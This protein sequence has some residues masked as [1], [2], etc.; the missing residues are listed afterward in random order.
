[1]KMMKLALL[2]G[3]ALAVTAAGAQADDLDALKAEI[4]ALNARVAQLEAAP[5]V[6]AGYQLVT[7]T[8]GDRIVIPG[9]EETD[10]G[11]GKTATIIS[12][13]PTADAPASTSIEWSGYARAALVWRSEGADEH[14]PEE[15]DW[16]VLARGEIKVVGKTDTAVGEVGATVKIRGDFDGRGVAGDYMKEAWGW[17]AMTPELFLGGGYTGSLGNIGYGI[18]GSCNCYYTDNFIFLD[19]GDTTQMRLT[20]KSGPFSA[21]AAIEDG[22]VAGRFFPTGDSMGG[23]GEVKYSGDMISG[24]ISAIWLNR[25]DLPDDFWQIGAGA[26]IALGDMANLSVAAGVGHTRGSN[27][28]TPPGPPLFT[29]A[30]GTDYWVASALVSVNLSDAV[31]AEAGYGHTEFDGARTDIDSA[32]AGIYYD[33]V[34]Q[35]TIGL[36][37]E[38]AS[39]SRPGPDPDDFTQVDL[40]TVFRF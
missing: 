33:P 8:R 25:D 1:M 24:E 4:E 34:S 10:P 29:K 39:F 22:S 6:P 12:V 37:A 20:W 27:V 35:L 31:H 17:W 5:S 3:A 32:L 16:D 23:A 38:W 11:Y 30:D 40:V 14:D 18:D 36:E 2:G 28:F 15:N 19:P 13:L 7:V 21:S 9:L 26:G